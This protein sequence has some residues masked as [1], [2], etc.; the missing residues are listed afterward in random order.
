MSGRIDCSKSTEEVSD[1]K[2]EVFRKLMWNGIHCGTSVYM[3]PIKL[4]TQNPELGFYLGTW[5][6]I[7]YLLLLSSIFH[8]SRRGSVVPP[9]IFSKIT[10][11]PRLTIACRW[12]LI[13]FLLTAIRNSKNW[14]W[15]FT[16]YACAGGLIKL[17]TFS[18]KFH[19]SDVP[20]EI[21]LDC[22]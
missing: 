1:D 16:A 3:S 14:R 5:T 7:F 15:V 6:I 22:L 12:R 2:T 19:N 21:H 10:V 18:L 8:I 11:V 13:Q 17:V 9:A 4:G 20:G